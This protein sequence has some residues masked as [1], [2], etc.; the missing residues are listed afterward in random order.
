MI[1][2]NINKTQLR[3]LAGLSSNVIAKLSKDDHVSMDS[4]IRICKALQ[5]DVGDIFEVIEESEQLT[6]FNYSY[7]NSSGHSKVAESKHNKR[8]QN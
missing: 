3:K 2:L 1:D 8:K 5:C 7:M 6:M 4:L